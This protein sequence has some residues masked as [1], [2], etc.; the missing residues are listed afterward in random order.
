[1]ANPFYV[2]PGGA[3]GPGLQGLSQSLMNINEIRQR[4]AQQAQQE[5]YRQRMLKMKE[6]E[7]ARQQQLLNQSQ[8]KE[9]QEN[10][11]FNLVADP[12]NIGN[13]ISELSEMFNNPNLEQ[14]FSNDPERFKTILENRARAINPKR[15]NEYKKSLLPSSDDTKEIRNYKMWENMPP[16]EKKD[17]FAKITG[18]TQAQKLTDEERNFL[19]WKDMPPGEEKNAFALSAGIK[20]RMKFQEQQ[21]RESEI[22]G[23]Q[24]N[25]RS[26]TE[27]LG[28]VGNLFTHDE[29]LDALSGYRGRFPVTLSPTATEA[30]LYLDN[31]KAALTLEN[32][33]KMKGLG[34][35]SDSDM[36]MIA[37]SAAAI[38]PGMR[39]DTIK[40]ELLKIQMKLRNSYAKSQN[41][42]KAKIKEYKK[43]S[44]DQESKPTGFEHIENDDDLLR[45]GTGAM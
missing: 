42:L 38:K 7:F 14:R 29:Y 28:I 9:Q 25:L 8:Q 22:E 17:A 4:Q 11:L 44:E 3:Y 33:S 39:K 2:Q 34:T 36:K 12:E 1:M 23:I 40:K 15:F 26:V 19:R 27:T 6:A 21:K 24:G 16:G 37:N 5:A 41:K 30:E 35:L 18:I 20:P 32:M 45:I 43:M 10:M 13:R 31:L